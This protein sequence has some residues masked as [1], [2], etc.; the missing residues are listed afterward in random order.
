[1]KENR[2]LW[3]D[4][5]ATWRDFAKKLDQLQILAESG[6]KEAA[7]TAFLEVEEARLRHNAAR[8]KLAHA[9]DRT[10]LVSDKTAA[11]S[12]TITEEH[13]IRET[14]RRIWEFAGRPENSAESDWRRAENLFR[15][16]AQ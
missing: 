11:T 9:L 12:G 5:R 4:Y 8:D 3:I 14:A 16:A 7:A 13:R 10:I 6:R 15:S 2:Q 1:M